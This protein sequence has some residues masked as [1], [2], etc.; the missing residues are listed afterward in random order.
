MQQK[1]YASMSD[2]IKNIEIRIDIDELIY[3]YNRIY[4]QF[5]IIVYMC[6]VLFY[7]IYRFDMF[8][9]NQTTLFI[10]SKI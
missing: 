9:P 1:Y 8:S 4:F 7:S 3:L 5:N 6:L 2:I 10:N